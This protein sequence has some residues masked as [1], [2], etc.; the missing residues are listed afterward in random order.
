M[1]VK[2]FAQRLRGRDCSLR[3]SILGVSLEE[4]RDG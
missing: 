4:S 3:V 1:Y 2:A